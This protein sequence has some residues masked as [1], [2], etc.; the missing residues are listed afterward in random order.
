MGKARVTLMI[1]RGA[2]LCCDVA[3]NSVWV[4]TRLDGH[5]DRH[6]ASNGYDIVAVW[7]R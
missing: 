4:C 3:P 5:G 7:D 1:E 2:N 6:A